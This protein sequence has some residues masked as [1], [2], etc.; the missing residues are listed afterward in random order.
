MLMTVVVV[1]DA[2][3]ERVVPNLIGTGCSQE[4]TSE[5]FAHKGKEPGQQNRGSGIIGIDQETG[6]YKLFCHENLLLVS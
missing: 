2:V 3:N 1:G 6:Y 5:V 4:E